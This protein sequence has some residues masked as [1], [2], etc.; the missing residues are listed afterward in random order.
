MK[1]LKFI[2]FILILSCNQP[3][4]KLI[5]RSKAIGILKS[6]ADSLYAAKRFEKAVHGYAALI[7]YDSSNGEYFFKHAYCLSLLQNNRQATEEFV[8]AAEKGYNPANSYY[9][10]ALNSLPFSDSLSYRFLI[11]ANEFDS[12]NIEVHQMITDLKSRLSFQK[13]L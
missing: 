4:K 1:Y 3:K 7:V 11:K 8:K 12:T 6:K 9:N 2:S 10:A 5:S 13:S